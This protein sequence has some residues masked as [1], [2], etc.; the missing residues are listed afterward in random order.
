MTMPMWI[1][2]EGCHNARDVGGLRTD[3]GSVTRSGVLLRSDDPDDLVP[4]DIDA[5]VNFHRLSAVVDL[6]SEFERSEASVLSDAGVQLLWWPL[7]DGNGPSSPRRPVDAIVTADDADDF[8]A[9]AYLSAADRFRMHV[10]ELN[11]TPR[12][13]AGRDPRPL[14]RR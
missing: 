6:R 4:G 8:L 12:L 3:D 7:H 10:P 9:A 11:G 14:L 13:D 2:L 1:E 5:L